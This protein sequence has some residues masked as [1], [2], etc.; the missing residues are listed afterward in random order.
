MPSPPHLSAHLPRAR[1]EH[2]LRELSLRGSIR[3]SE[4][5][6]QLG[7][8]EVTIRRDIIH[9]EQ[10]GHLARVHGGAISAE[11]TTRPA[12]ARTPIGLLLPGAGSHF[13][14][15]TR[16]AHEAALALHARLAM[17]SRSFRRRGTSA[18]RR[19]SWCAVRAKP[20][21]CRSSTSRPWSAS[22]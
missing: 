14:E 10:G 5:A 6:A 16:G 17:A 7:V 8:S 4:V 11:A 3:A 12:P 20:L 15:V 22:W 13:P 21:R 1:H 19:S 9:L 2:L 18:S